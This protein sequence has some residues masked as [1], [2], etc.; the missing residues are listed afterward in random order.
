MLGLGMSLSSRVL[1]YHAQGPGFNHHHL[2]KRNRK[3]EMLGE[4]N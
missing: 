3:E 1:V 4:E 2:K